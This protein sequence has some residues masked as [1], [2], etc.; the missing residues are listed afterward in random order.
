MTRPADIKATD[1]NGNIT[2]AKEVAFSDPLVTSNLKYLGYN[3][4]YFK[5]P[6]GTKINLDTSDYDDSGAQLNSLVTDGK[7]SVLTFKL[8]AAGIQ[9]FAAEPAGT[10]LTVPIGTTVNPDVTGK[11]INTFDTFYQGTATNTIIHEHSGTTDPLKDGAR[12]VDKPVLPT[13]AD[14][15][16]PVIY[17]GNV[18][19]HKTNENGNN[20]AHA[21]FKLYNSKTDAEAGKNPVQTGPSADPS[22][23]DHDLT[24]VSNA[25]GIAEFTGLKVDPTTQQQTYW[26]VE[27]DAPVGYDLNGQVFEVTA[28]RDT[29]VDATVKDHDNVLPNLP[30]TG[31]DGRL[32]LYEVAALLIGTGGLGV[33]FMKRRHAAP[34]K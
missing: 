10:K 32:L 7:Y 15:G 13:N 34:T 19:I 31:R 30:L 4:P 11:I 17:T 26:V 23:P 24:A 2:Y 29:T 22:V 12:D 25:Q 9:K 33:I 8:K 16:A 21:T 18:D 14:T 27:T 1:D 28:K 3:T 5:E 6:D 20:V